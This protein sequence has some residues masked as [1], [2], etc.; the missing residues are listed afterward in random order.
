MWGA[1]KLFFSN[2]VSR[3]IEGLG[4][5][6]AFLGIV[7]AIF[8]AGKKSEKADEIVGELKQVKNAHEIEDKNRANLHDGDAADK[9][10]KDWSR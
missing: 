10:R 6:A 8:N 5:I 2:N 9:L 1:V 7:A 4:I 3:I